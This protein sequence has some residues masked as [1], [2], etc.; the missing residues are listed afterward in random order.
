MELRVKSTRLLQPFWF[1][2]GSPEYLELCR[3]E[4]LVSAAESAGCRAN[5]LELRSITFH[6]PLAD[7]MRQTRSRWS[8]AY[9][10]PT[11]N[12]PRVTW[13]EINGKA[14]F[15]RDSFDVDESDEQ[16]EAW[17]NA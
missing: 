15:A 6:W 12:H 7:W 8:E 1:E 2:G 13:S 4:L 10:V 14:L 16:Q 3:L 11:S 9:G 5:N 17:V